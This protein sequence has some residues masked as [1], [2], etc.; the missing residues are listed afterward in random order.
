MSRR[1]K[2]YHQMSSCFIKLF[3]LQH[4]TDFAKTLRLNGAIAQPVPCVPHRPRNHRKPYDMKRKVSSA[5]F[6]TETLKIVTPTPA[7]SYS[8]ACA[9]RNGAVMVGW[10]YFLL[11][12]LS[13]YNN[14]E[15]ELVEQWVTRYSSSWVSGSPGDML[16]ERSTD[17]TFRL[18]HPATDQA[19]SPLRVARAIEGTLVSS[20]RGSWFA[21][22]ARRLTLLR[23]DAFKPSCVEKKW[24]KDVRVD[25]KPRVPGRIVLRVGFNFYEPISNADQWNFSV[26]RKMSRSSKVWGSLFWIV[27]D[28]SIFSRNPLMPFQLSICEH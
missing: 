3:N 16:R 12:I 22:D 11:S 4:Y 21:T 20:H 23:W 27:F 15:V 14:A 25:A 18:Y 1:A 28:S 24:E 5:H 6:T 19:V 17:A 8:C 26:A 9:F 10:W 13:D 7:P 2:R